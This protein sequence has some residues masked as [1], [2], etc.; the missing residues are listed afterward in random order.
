MA[1]TVASKDERKWINSLVTLGSVLVLFI[2]LRLIE[3]I[4]VWT[5][6][7]AKVANFQY[8]SLAVSIVL[9]VTFFL[10]VT[11][12]EKTSVYIHEVLKEALKVIW[13]IVI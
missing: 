11:K 6:L 9:G 4:N 13:P 8:I 5:E 2:S 10:V 12:N 1:K 7:E 3:L